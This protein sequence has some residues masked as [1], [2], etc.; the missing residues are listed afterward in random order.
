MLNLTAPDAVNVILG[1]W[2]AISWVSKLN[3][4]LEVEVISK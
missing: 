3:N 2:L 1:T 4:K